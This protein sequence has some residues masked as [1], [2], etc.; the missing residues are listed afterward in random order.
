MD[1]QRADANKEADALLAELNGLGKKKSGSDDDSDDENAGNS[2]SDDSDEDA[3]S[4]SDDEQK[5]TKEELEDAEK[6]MAEIDSV[7]DAGAEGSEDEAPKKKQTAKNATVCKSDT[8]TVCQMGGA[9]TVEVEGSA[10]KKSKKR[11]IAE[12]DEDEPASDEEEE[13]AINKEDSDDDETEND[14]SDDE[15]DESNP[16]LATEEVV[17]DKSESQID[18]KTARQKKRLLSAADEDAA[19][20]PDAK[21]QKK[22]K[23]ADDEDE[24]ALLNGELSDEDSNNNSAAN[25]FSSHSIFSNVDAENSSQ[26]D[27]IKAAFAAETSFENELG[28]DIMDKLKKEE[29]KLNE[30]DGT[31]GWGSWAGLGVRQR[32]KKKRITLDAPKSLK[33]ERSKKEDSTFASKY[34]VDQ[35]PFQYQSKEQYEQTLCAPSGQEW[36]PLTMHKYKIAPK[37]ITRLGTVVKPLSYAKNVSGK[38]RDE[39]LDGW[40]KSKKAQRPKAKF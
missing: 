24:D 29:D 31:K 18:V 1:K 33:V 14:H 38:E 15:K 6:E 3:E 37:V 4:D 21:K 40:T 26:V 30:D 34:K 9:V 12:V 35:L 10:T 36:N 11:P 19:G 16:W 13:K 20:M 8:K 27:L 5:F 32:K 7:Q 2:N 22:S 23:S 25:A 39:I 17:P 28:Q